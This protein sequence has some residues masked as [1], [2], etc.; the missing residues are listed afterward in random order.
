MVIET[1]KF[2][3][4]RPSENNMVRFMLHINEKEAYSMLEVSGKN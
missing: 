1:L 3:N 4:G 2:W